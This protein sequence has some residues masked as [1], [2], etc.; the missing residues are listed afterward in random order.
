[1]AEMLFRALDD[2]LTRRDRRQRWATPFFSPTISLMPLIDIE[3]QVI[4]K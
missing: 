2:P 4:L 3:L 1:M